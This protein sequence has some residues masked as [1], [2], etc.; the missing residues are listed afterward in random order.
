MATTPGEPWKIHVVSA[1]GGSPQELLAEKR[2]EGHPDWSPD[3][4]MLAFG[5][6]PWL[7]TE[8]SGTAA[9]MLLDLRTQQLSRLLASEGLFAPRW[10]PDGRYIVAAGSGLK[11]FDF[12][13][14]KWVELA[15]DHYANYPNWSRDGDYV[16]FQSWGHGFDV[17]RVA[18]DTRKLEKLVSLKDLRLVFLFPFQTE[19]WSG[20]APDDSP[21]F[22]RNISSQ[23]IYALDWE[24]P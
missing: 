21:L 4:N 23:E 19:T 13:T 20:L 8:T 3:G 22:L 14:Q 15:K 17:F 9:I 6:V 18:V 10:S 11:L 1:E 2:H 16:Y 5:R 7:G 12:K 24:A